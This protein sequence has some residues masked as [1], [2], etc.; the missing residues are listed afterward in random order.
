MDSQDKRLNP[1]IRLTHQRTLNSCGLN[2]FES[3]A[4]KTP[5]MRGVLVKFKQ[6]LFYVALLNFLLHAADLGGF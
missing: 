2:V 6:T 4:T 5:R 1:S 3:E